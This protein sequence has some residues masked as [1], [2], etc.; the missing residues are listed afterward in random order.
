M[1]EVII[2]LTIGPLP[3]SILDSKT[4]PFELLLKSLLRSK[5]SACS[6][7]S[8]KSL[9]ILFFVYA[10]ISTIIVSPDKSS[11]ISSCSKS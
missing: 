8:S 7:I 3:M 5:I 9:S 2:I 1:P 4:I 10:E 6:K 11:A